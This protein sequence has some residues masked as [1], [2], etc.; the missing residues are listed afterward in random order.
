MIIEEVKSPCEDCF[1]SPSCFIKNPSTAQPL[2][3]DVVGLRHCEKLQKYNSFIETVS[4]Y[5]NNR[6]IL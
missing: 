2:G 1:H 5:N 3:S 6:T 4:G